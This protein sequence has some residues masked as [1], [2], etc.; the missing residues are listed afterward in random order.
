MAYWSKT[1]ALMASASLVAMHG[2]AQAQAVD[3]V[4]AAEA[5]A[6][7]DET[8]AGPTTPDEDIVV[9]GSRIA[10]TTFQTPTPVTSIGEK[11]L[12]AKAATSAVDL[13]RD[14]PA[15]RPNQTVGSG[16]NIGVSN[17]NMRSLGPSRT[18]VLLDGQRLMDTSPVG[19]FDINVIPAPLISR[20]E[21][22]TA[23]ASSVY[24]SDAVTG[25]VNM[26]LN[27]KYEGAKVDAQYSQSTHGDLNTYAASLI[28]GTKFA[29]GRGHFV[30][31]GSYRETPN[32][33]Y[34][35]AR[36]WG[37][38]GWTLL[39]N[40]SYTAT[41]GQ[42]R[43]VIVPNARLSSMT[44]GGLITTAGALKNI[45]F[46]ANG[47]QSLFVQGTNVGTVW[48]EGGDGLMP[49]PDFALIAT[50]A[51]QFSGL[52]RLTYEV[53][54]D[55][56]ASV[57]VLAA[58]SRNQATNNWNY[59]NG[60]ITINRDN[61]YLPANILAQM[62]SNNLQTVK[63]GRINPEMGV[64]LNTTTN[65]YLRVGAGLKGPLGGSWKWDVSASY[66]HARSENLGQ[67]NRN[68][69][70]WN[71]AIDPVMGPN[72]QVI[73]RSTLTNPTDGCVPANVFGLNSL[74]PAVVA[75][76]SGT[77]YQRS[78][79]NS[80]DVAGNLSG[81]L[82]ATWAGP[83]KLATGI[84]YRRDTVDNKSDPISDLN[85]WRQGTFASYYGALRVWEGY[86]EAS[87]PLASES[88][89]AKSLDL[90][91]AGRY[92]NYSTSGSTAV[93]K[94][95]LNWA[96]NDSIRF[97]GTYS[98]DFRA[99]KID[100]LYSASS[101]RAGNTVIDFVNNKSANVNT[102]AGGNPKLKPE[103]AH[104]FTAGVVLQPSF[105]P[106]LQFSVDYFNI[107]LRDAITVPTPQE[108]VNRC[109]AGDQ[110]F[111]AGILRDSTGTITQVQVTTFNAQ[112]L[113]TSGLDF[114]LSYQI[115]LGSG[116]L[117]LRTV[118]TYTDRLISSTGSGSV[119]TAG[120][121]TGTYATP[122]WRGST[123]ISYGQGPFNF[124]VLFNYVGPGKYDNT[125]GALDLNRN[126]YPAFLY[127]DLS[128]QYD[129]S[130]NIQLYAKVENLLDTDPP[131]IAANTITVAAASSSQFYD[132]RGRVVGVGARLKF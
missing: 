25:V 48:M 50:A 40:A 101:L 114:E 59:N 85:G 100:D 18:L 68:N 29:D 21:I 34:Q 118:A 121:L 97:R 81:D 127:T 27:T 30:I 73:C 107:D 49:Q 37:S 63:L 106:R 125:Y 5:V 23:G 28:Y 4:L 110:T 108:V 128:A 71:K 11:Q 20:M 53:T 103:V 57:D 126:N 76:A 88:A 98:K 1:C 111:C 22:V 92:V 72:G 44:L 42:F 69:I 102:L 65:D 36:D 51:R 130:D 129:V 2:A 84:E 10:R 83:I 89:F 131:L 117:G 3:A 105:I 113:K 74:T 19:G 115:P 54:P 94:V 31:A 112:T 38:Q 41:N 15:L 87:V 16:R 45:Q 46:G 17:F 82:G 9:T 7:A 12:E 79:S 64:N 91:L 8:R 109:A 58:R 62:V 67:N 77:S 86:G 61:P 75:Y 52:S 132:M 33:V 80:V 26:I 120:Q 66:T 35:G 70:N 93:W 78:Y 90:D 55:V 96:V 95:G 116:E 56:E 123:T 122:K 124:R 6:P 24:G 104:T 13:L 119:D 39:P 47:Q 14:V 32:M 43:Q 60:D 99:P